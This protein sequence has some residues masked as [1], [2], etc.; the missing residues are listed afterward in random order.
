[1]TSPPTVIANA[2]TKAATSRRPRTRYTVGFGARP[3][4]FLSRI[5]PDRVFDAFIKRASGVPA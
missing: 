1:M 3:L 2:V 4:V 5:L